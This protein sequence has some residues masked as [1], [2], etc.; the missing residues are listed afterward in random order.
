[1]AAEAVAA[2]LKRLYEEDVKAWVVRFNDILSSYG[3][4]RTGVLLKIG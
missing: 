4:R 2:D 1:M 3:G